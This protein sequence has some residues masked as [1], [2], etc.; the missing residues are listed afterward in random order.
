MATP[1]IFVTH[2][3]IKNPKLR[4]YAVFGCLKLRHERRPCAF[5]ASMPFSALD[6]LPVPDGR[7]GTSEEI[8]DL[9]SVK[10]GKLISFLISSCLL[11]YIRMLTW[12]HCVSSPGLF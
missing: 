4:L 6:P 3:M 12:Y 9:L 8:R 1:G 7:S 2:N 10:T 5:Y 11:N